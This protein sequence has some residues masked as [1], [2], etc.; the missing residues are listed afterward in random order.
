MNREQ[1]LDLVKQ[2][3]TEHRFQHTL[4]VA[5][6]AVWL[7]KRYGADPDK[8][9]LAAILHDYCKFWPKEKLEQR[10]MDYALDAELLQYDKELW[11][12][13][14][15]AEVVKKEFAIHDEDVLNAIRYH[16]SGRVDMSL[17]EK[18]VCLADYLEPGRDFPGI[19]GLREMSRE[20]LDRALLACFD[21]TIKFLLSRGKKVFPL[22]LM[23][24]NDL[25]DQVNRRGSIDE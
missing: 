10:I 16:T 13:P 17:L 18:V 20:D 5:K 1:M 9:D 23:A 14:V 22:T 24:R 21:N 7:A 4:G 8:A 15:G 3:M 2:Q 11:H 12:A 6:T 19:E 25:V